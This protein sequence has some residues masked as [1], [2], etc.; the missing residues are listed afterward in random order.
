LDK[1]LTSLYL[2]Q[3]LT[4]RT[5]G[6]ETGIN[7]GGFLKYGLISAA[8][9]A[10]A[11]DPNQQ[12]ITGTD[13]G[14]RRWK[15]LG[16]ARLA[17]SVG[18]ADMPGYRM[19]PEINFFGARKGI[20]LGGHY[21]Y[22]GGTDMN[23]DTSAVKYDNTKKTYSGSVKYL[24]GFNRNSSCGFDAVANFMGL[25][26]DG[27]YDFMSRS[28]S[29]ISYHHDSVS[30]AS[31]S[32][33]DRVYHIRGGYAFPVAKDQFIEPAAMYSKFVGDA[34]SAVYPG[35][36]DEIIDAGLNWY[37]K[38][39]NL[40]ITLHYIRQS[41]QAVSNYEPA[42]PTASKETVRGDMVAANFQVQL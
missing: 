18:Q 17:L 15:P 25:S 11:F 33:T 19:S 10:G 13:G 35:G 27:E 26:V 22:Q 39:N 3:F 2:R 9:N 4:G 5:S 14:S 38:K 23:W 21:A 8:Y 34:K 31:A 16:V 36:L 30:A 28:I 6:R 1:G 42:V 40:K 12:M 32:Y 24:G 37:I 41:G 20:T 7:I 29:G